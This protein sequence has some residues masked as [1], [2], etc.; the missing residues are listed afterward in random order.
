LPS[1]AARAR[2]P[3]QALI[4]CRTNF[5][6]DNLERFLNA[7]GGGG[8]FRGGRESGREDAY[9]CAV[10]A[11]QRA[12]EQRREALAA[13]RPLTAP[14]AWPQPRLVARAEPPARRAPARAAARG[15]WAPLPA[16]RAPADP[17]ALVVSGPCSA[18]HARVHPGALTPARSMPGRPRLQAFREGSV[19]LLIATDVAARGLD[20]SGLP[21]VVNMTLP[22]RSE[23]YIHRVG[24]VGA[25]PPPSCASAQAG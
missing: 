12:M 21:C 6:C 20:I 13:R 9:A 25:R 16:A 8:G 5:D 10:L 14:R 7:A 17:A 11:G 2:R 24:R 4:F 18:A 22:D 19:R 23:D 3:G 15:C 1:R